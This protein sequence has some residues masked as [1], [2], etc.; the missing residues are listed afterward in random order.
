MPSRQM[1]L[2]LSMNPASSSFGTEPERV[3]ALL[4]MTR[5]VLKGCKI[6]GDD[7]DADK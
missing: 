7:D 2:Y 6:R 5:R 1:A 3:G 4:K